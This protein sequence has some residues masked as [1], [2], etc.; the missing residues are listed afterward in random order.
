[1]TDPWLEERV[2]SQRAEVIGAAWDEEIGAAEVTAVLARLES[3]RKLKSRV[4]TK[5]VLVFTH[6]HPC[7]WNCSSRATSWATTSVR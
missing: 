5:K 4:E 6:A 2:L 7:T 3:E 1:M